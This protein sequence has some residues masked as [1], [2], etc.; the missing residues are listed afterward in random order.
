MAVYDTYA[1]V[2]YFIGSERGMMFAP[3]DVEFSLR[4]AEVYLTL[5]ERA[6]E[7]PLRTP[8]STPRR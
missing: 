2:E 1:W 8:W 3:I 6:R 5:L 4:A 7:R